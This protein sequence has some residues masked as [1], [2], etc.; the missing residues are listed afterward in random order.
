MDKRGKRCAQIL[1]K[2]EFIINAEEEKRKR[3]K[4]NN[5]IDMVNTERRKETQE[6][7]YNY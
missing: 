4:K 2:N 6:A 1:N 3:G 7:P 5:R